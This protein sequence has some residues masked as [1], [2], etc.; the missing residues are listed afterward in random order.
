MKARELIEILEN[1]HPDE[2][3][4][5]YT[6]QSHRVL[7]LK[8]YDPALSSKLGAV[9]FT[10][11][12]SVTEGKVKED[13][14]DKMKKE[15]DMLTAKIAKM[16]AEQKAELSRKTHKKSK[17]NRS[18]AVNLVNDILKEQADAPKRGR[19]PKKRVLETDLADD[20]TSRSQDSS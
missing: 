6:E 5:L 14:V 1:C 16:T 11:D 8:G 10:V 17:S 7:L 12:F 9:T 4:A 20:P 2:D 18:A 3:V 13:P 19:P 15:R